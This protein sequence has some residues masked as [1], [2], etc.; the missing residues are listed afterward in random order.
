[1]VRPTSVGNSGTSGLIGASKKGD[2]KVLLQE[3][4]INN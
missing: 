1:M 3:F 2:K 4:I